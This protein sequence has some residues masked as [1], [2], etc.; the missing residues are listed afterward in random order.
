[1]P[2]PL[3]LGNG[4]GTVPSAQA[5]RR[6]RIGEMS[7]GQAHLELFPVPRLAVIEGPLAATGEDMYTA[8]RT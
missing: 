5:H 1:M 6:D 4:R 2:A 8:R 7:L 3:T